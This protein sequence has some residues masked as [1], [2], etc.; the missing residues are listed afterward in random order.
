MADKKPPRVPVQERG[1]K[2]RE[3]IVEAGMALFRERGY[4]KINAIDIA[5]QAGLATGTLY[6]YFNN[7][8]EILIECLLLFFKDVNMHIT[9]SAVN[10][11]QSLANGKIFIRFLIQMFYESLDMNPELYREICS[12]IMLDKNVQTICR[13]EDK[14]IINMMAEFFERNKH[15][16]Q[17]TDFSAASTMIYR[18][19]IVMIQEIKLFNSD[20]EKERLLDQLSN[21]ISNYLFKRD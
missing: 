14:K 19:C 12:M 20:I 3:K 4:H 13:D 18:T 8:K 21:M 1:I 6:T 17:I 10:I 9:K 15:L 2:T 16:F 11:D 5:H 7:K